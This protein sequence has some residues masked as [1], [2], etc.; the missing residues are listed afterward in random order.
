M[1]FSPRFS[2]QDADG[3]DK[4]AMTPE[5]EFNMTGDR[6][7]SLRRIGPSSALVEAATENVFGDA[8]LEN[9]H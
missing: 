4:P 5:K 9:F 2:R 3:R 6:C 7:R 1:S 8:V